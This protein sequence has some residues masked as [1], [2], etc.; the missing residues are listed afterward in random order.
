MHQ[1]VRTVYR[2]IN[3][4]AR[5]RRPVRLCVE[6]LEDRCTPASLHPQMALIA[7]YVPVLHAQ[8]SFL[9]MPAIDAPAANGTATHAAPLVRTDLFGGAVNESS[10]TPDDGL[11]AIEEPFAALDS[12]LDLKAR[13]RSE[14]P[15]VRP[16]E[17]RKDTKD[18]GDPRRETHDT[19]E[20][21][22]ACILLEYDVLVE[23]E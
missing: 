22:A 12:T 11:L 23:A 1:Y 7:A 8:P 17:V 4:F 6:V 21:Y 20:E 19:L 18:W 15:A 13:H 9:R 2:Q 14:E 3:R 16:E 5:A 10:D